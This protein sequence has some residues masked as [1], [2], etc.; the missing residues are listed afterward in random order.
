MNT[1]KENKNTE[2]IKT[3]K[4]KVTGAI[5]S[6]ATQILI[7]QVLTIMEENK[8]TPRML[9]WDIGIDEGQFSRWSKCKA[10]FSIDRIQAILDYLGY[11]MTIT[12]KDSK[13]S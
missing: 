1:L 8:I 13:R 12:P 11:E 4:R 6:P 3:P 2:E 9:C 5:P 7:A 10:N